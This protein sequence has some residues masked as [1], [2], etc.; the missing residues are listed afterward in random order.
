M[1][2]LK[3]STIGTAMLLLLG[4]LTVNLSA[5]ETPPP[6]TQDTVQMIP[7]TTKV[8]TLKM[9]PA[10]IVP[11]TPVETAQVAP[12]M[13]DTFKKAVD[14]VGVK[15]DTIPTEKTSRMIEPFELKVA[16]EPPFFM[17][18]IA[19]T[20]SRS[21]KGSFRVPDF[22]YTLN[23]TTKARQNHNIMMDLLKNAAGIEILEAGQ[24]LARPAIRGVFGS[25]VLLLQDG[26]RMNTFR[27]FP[28]WG[29]S[30]TLI[31]VDQVEK[32]EI[33][34]GP[35]SHLYGSDAY[36]GVINFITPKPE[37]LPE[38]E[39]E[40]GYDLSGSYKFSYSSIGEQKKNRLELKLADKKWALN[41]G[42]SFRKVPHNYKSGGENEQVVANTS[43]KEESSVDLNLGYKFRENQTFY[44]QGSRNRDFGIGFAN[45]YS[46]SFPFQKRDRAA[47][48]YEVQDLAEKIPWLN[49]K[50]FFQEQRRLFQLSLPPDTLNNIDSDVKLWGGAVQGLYLV[51]PHQTFSVGAD[52]ASERIKGGNIL[53]LEQ[54]KVVLDDTTKLLPEIHWDMAGV[55]M[56]DEITIVPNL[57]AFLGGRYDYHQIKHFD[58]THAG[59]PPEERFDRYISYQSGL[60]YRFQKGYQLNF[61]VARSYRTPTV[62]E[63]YYFG[64]LDGKNWLSSNDRLKK[65]RAINVSLGAKANLDAFSGSVSWFYKDLRNFIDLRPATGALYQGKQIWTWK[66]LAGS[67]RMVGIEGAAEVSFTE[68]FYG[69]SN[70]SWIWGQHRRDTT[71][72]RIDT[73]GAFEVVFVPPFKAYFGIG[74]KEKEG[75]LWAEISSRVVAQQERI[76]LNSQGQKILSNTSGFAIYN[77]RGGINLSNRQVLTLAFNNIANRF[78][79]EPYN[80]FNAAANNTPLAPEPGRN[81]SISLTVSY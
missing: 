24:F 16:E 59:I 72:Q 75:R 29:T 31:D 49:L 77:L 53:F 52:F 79:V 81:F 36:G 30:P 43:I 8:D 40:N 14:T 48:T 28:L 37:F 74:W 60:V 25:R 69:F 70:W 39:M 9:E 23:P 38:G 64:P 51:P 15:L 54:A 78:Y 34:N 26:V 66:N 80:Q 2:W 33:L 1:I 35:G 19:F 47:L 10:P 11:P 55:Y 56:L 22:I 76:P 27:D 57:S 32:I 13:A 3:G 7:E 58:T 73:A 21:D 42:G 46:M 68:E 45:L 20:T 17:K 63:R 6:V 61:S 18:E 41:L 44:F 65:E 50:G 12:P 67:T 5:Q 4:V 71:A 62:V